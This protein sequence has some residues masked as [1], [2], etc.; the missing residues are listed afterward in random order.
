MKRS[1]V[2]SLLEALLSISNSTGSSSCTPANAH[3]DL[4]LAIVL[5]ARDQGVG[6]VE[7]QG[8]PEEDQKSGEG[9]IDP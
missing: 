3:R 9:E 7:E 8:A 1:G 6:E 4:I 2:A 5:G